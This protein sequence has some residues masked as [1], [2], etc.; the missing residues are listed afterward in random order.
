MPMKKWM[1]EHKK[2]F[3][4]YLD[5]HRTENEDDEPNLYDAYKHALRSTVCLFEQLLLIEIHDQA[6]KS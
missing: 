1:K 5:E 4:E 2:F 3:Q 6:E